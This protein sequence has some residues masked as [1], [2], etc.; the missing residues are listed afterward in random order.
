MQL[1]IYALKVPRNPVHF[2]TV[3]CSAPTNH[4][5][6]KFVKTSVHMSKDRASCYNVCYV[7]KHATVNAT[8]AGGSGG[9]A[10]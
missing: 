9:S 4:P 3:S 7:T 5:D 8:V 10:H 2:D 1:S 6:L